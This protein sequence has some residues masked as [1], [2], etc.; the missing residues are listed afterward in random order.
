[1]AIPRV[2]DSPQCPVYAVQD[3]LVTAGIESE[4]IIRRLHRA[5]TVGHTRLSAQSVA[6]IN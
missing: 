2:E 3:W 1:M 4:A 6:L 5:D